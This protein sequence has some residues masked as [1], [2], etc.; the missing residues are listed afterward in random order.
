MPLVRALIIRRV[1][2]CMSGAISRRAPWAK[3]VRDATA[4]GA[5]KALALVAHRRRPIAER[6]VLVK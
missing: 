4:V 3:A 5:E 1:G 6:I 2:P